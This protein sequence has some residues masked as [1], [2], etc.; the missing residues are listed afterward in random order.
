MIMTNQP[1]GVDFD[2]QEEPAGN[3]TVGREGGSPTMIIIHDMEAAASVGEAWLE[4][5]ASHVSAHYGIDGNG[6]IVKMVREHDT[7]WH[8]GNWRYNLKSVGIEHAGHAATPADYTDAML[9]ASAKLVAEICHR[10]GISV[11]RQHIIGHAEVP[12]PNHAGQFG[13]LDHHTDPGAGWPWGRYMALV[14]NALDAL[15]SV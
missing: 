8:C 4:N 2:W 15:H 5:P 13:G 14:Q 9:A 11:D 1:N 3:Y 6:A 7:A 10:W 12:D